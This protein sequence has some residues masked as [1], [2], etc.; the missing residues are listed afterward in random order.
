MN[1]NIKYSY[2]NFGKNTFRIYLKKGIDPD[3]GIV[4][5]YEIQEPANIP[6]NRWE[7]LKQFFTVKTYHWGYWVPSISDDTL[8]DR[9]ALTITSIVNAQTSQ[10]M[11]D[12]EWEAF[13]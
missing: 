2:R 11:A 6:H 1:N 13:S 10:N 12:K 8:E 7:Q 9:I 5:K 4:V 3:F